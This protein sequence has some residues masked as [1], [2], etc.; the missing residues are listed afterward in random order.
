MKKT[1]HSLDE[2]T[3]LNRTVVVLKVVSRIVFGDLH[4]PSESSL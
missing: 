1:S 2:E 3:G 4:D